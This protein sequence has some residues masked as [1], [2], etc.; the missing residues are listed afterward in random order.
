MKGTEKLWAVISSGVDN[1]TIK[2]RSDHRN[3]QNAVDSEFEENPNQISDNLHNI[4][5][6][7]QVVFCHDDKTKRYSPN[8]TRPVKLRNLNLAYS[9]V[10]IL[11]GDLKGL[12]ICQWRGSRFVI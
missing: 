7:L 10:H 6:D 12:S 3:S 11:L 4:Y 9:M 8:L 1:A 2:G 5:P